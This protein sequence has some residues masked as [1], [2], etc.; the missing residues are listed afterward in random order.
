MTNDGRELPGSEINYPIPILRQ[1]RKQAPAVLAGAC[2]FVR[3]APACLAGAQIPVYLESP[4][5]MSC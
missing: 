5:S 1:D 2:F 4:K 3:D